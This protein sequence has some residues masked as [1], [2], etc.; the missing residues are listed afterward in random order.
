MLSCDS[1]RSGSQ[2]DHAAPLICWRLCSRPTR[3]RTR[4]RDS[5]QGIVGTDWSYPS[6][7]LACSLLFTGE[8]PYLS[9]SKSVTVWNCYHNK[10]F[11]MTLS[12]VMPV[13]LSMS[14]PAPQQQMLGSFSQDN[15]ITPRGYSVVHVLH[16][17]PLRLFTSTVVS[18][19]ISRVT[20][21]Q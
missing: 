11:L 8:Q 16:P 13:F 6:G 20:V 9:F 19:S 21:T 1:T 17:T 12:S 14:H 4:G 10:A 18:L 2:H 5:R 3:S 7:I 15:P